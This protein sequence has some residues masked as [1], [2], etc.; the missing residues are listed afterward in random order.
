MPYSPQ[1]IANFASDGV[2]NREIL[3]A[4]GKPVRTWEILRDLYNHQRAETA[5]MAA[6]QKLVAE[7]NGLALA[8][9]RRVVGEEV[10]KVI[11]KG[12]N[13]NLTVATGDAAS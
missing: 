2:A 10:D 12:V 1:E 5:A 13:V 4:N 9:V 6:L 3:S 11:A 8:D 7:Q